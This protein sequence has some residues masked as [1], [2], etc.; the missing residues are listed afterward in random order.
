M[1]DDCDDD[2]SDP[3]SSDDP[4]I[5]STE[6]EDGRTSAEDAQSKAKATAKAKS[7]RPLVPLCDLPEQ[8]DA[9]LVL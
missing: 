8:I 5:G 3:S 9:P 6:G 4:D 7:K 2:N 1:G